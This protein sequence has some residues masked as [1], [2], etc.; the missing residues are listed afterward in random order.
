MIFLQ[1]NF[2][3]PSNYSVVEQYHKLVCIRQACS[4]YICEIDSSVRIIRI[5]L[6]AHLKAELE[7]NGGGIGQKTL[8]SMAGKT[9]QKLKQL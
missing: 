3:N 2:S 4:I 9:G 6:N 5:G 1:D 8:E 7:A